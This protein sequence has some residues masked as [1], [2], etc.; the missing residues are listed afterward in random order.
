MTWQVMGS[1]VK[2]LFAYVQF[3]ESCIPML[4]YLYIFKDPRLGVLASPS[5]FHWGAV[6]QPGAGGDVSQNI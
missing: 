2:Q 4:S 1:E 5:I 3:G 6:A